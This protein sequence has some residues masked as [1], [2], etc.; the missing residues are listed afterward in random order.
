MLERYVFDGPFTYQCGDERI[1]I[2]SL[3]SLLNI[4]N[5]AFD[6]EISERLY[7]ELIHSRDSFVE[8]Y[9]QFNNRTSLIHQSMTFS[10]LPDTI[11][12]L[13]GCNISKIMVL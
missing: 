8:S 5:D 6:I 11:N 10:M 4:L 1:Q 9:K 2:T 3:E 12:F 13:H 7:H